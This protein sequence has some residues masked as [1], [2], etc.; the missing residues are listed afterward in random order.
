MH[1]WVNEWI[2]DGNATKECPVKN[3]FINFAEKIL[4]KP[5]AVYVE[6]MEYA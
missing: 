5:A 3:P 1:V 6:E 4:E 2:T